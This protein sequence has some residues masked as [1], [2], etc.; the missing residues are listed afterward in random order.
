MDNL[1]V[2]HCLTASSIACDAQQYLRVPWPWY[3]NRWHNQLQ[4]HHILHVQTTTMKSTYKSANLPKEANAKKQ[5][6]CWTIQKCEQMPPNETMPNPSSIKT[7]IRH[8]KTITN[9]GKLIYAET[10]EWTVHAFIDTTD[11]I[12]TQLQPK[13]T[14]QQWKMKYSLPTPFQSTI[15]IFNTDQT[16]CDGLSLGPL[17]LFSLQ[18]PMPLSLFV[19]ITFTIKG[20]TISDT[21]MLDSICIVPVSWFPKEARKHTT[22]T[23]K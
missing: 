9:I 7:E 18:K 2:I 14:S 22:S 4:H 6:G 3:Q 19:R 5:T 12:N 23:W 1:V 20:T 8:T 16:R 21:T 17:N 10:L 11:Y 13:N 15:W